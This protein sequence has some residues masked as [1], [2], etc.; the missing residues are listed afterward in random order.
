MPLSVG[1]E[2]ECELLDFDLTDSPV[3]YDQIVTKLNEALVSGVKV[4]GCYD[5]GRKIR[6]LLLLRCVITLEYDH[7]YTKETLDSIAALF[8]RDSLTVL[9][10]GKNG[11]VDQDIIPMIRRLHVSGAGE[12]EVAIEA[13][14]CCQ[15]PSIN[16]MQLVAAIERYCPEWKP[17]HATSRRIELYD[18]NETI[19]R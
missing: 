12:K 16:P 5:D 18:T 4:R 8:K 15:N 7:G 1:V 6:D 19:F 2:S 11:I 13:V 17:D 14:V 9:K 3:S 10:K